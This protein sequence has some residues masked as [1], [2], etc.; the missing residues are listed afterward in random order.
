M[1]EKWEEK[2]KDVDTM[3]KD[4]TADSRAMRSLM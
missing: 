3:K 2:R 4:R 1:V